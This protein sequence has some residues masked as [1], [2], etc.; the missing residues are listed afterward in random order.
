MYIVPLSISYA[1][2]VTFHGCFITHGNR[3]Q[4]GTGTHLNANT[5]AHGTSN[6][7]STCSPFFFFWLHYQ[8]Y[9]LERD[10]V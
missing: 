2:P 4:T 9:A 3:K 10:N 1:Y 7:D 8:H 5:R 6:E